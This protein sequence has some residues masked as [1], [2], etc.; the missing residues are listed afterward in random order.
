MEPDSD[1]GTSAKRIGIDAAILIAVLSLLVAIG[2][3]VFSGRQWKESHNQLLLAMA[4]SISF[5]T[6]A[7]TSDHPR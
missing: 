1:K 3:T 7:G 5:S 4:P 2:A 6:D